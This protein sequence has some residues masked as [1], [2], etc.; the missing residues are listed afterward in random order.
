VAPPRPPPGRASRQSARG[1][2][3]WDE[4]HVVHRLAEHLALL[5]QHA[6]DAE[7]TVA[8]DDVLP[9]RIGPLKSCALTSEPIT[10]TGS[11]SSVSIGVRNR[12]CSTI[13][14]DVSMYSSVVPR[15][16][17]ISSRSPR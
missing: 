10:T 9:Q 6:H 16:C 15:T 14:D 3:R 4:D 2:A 1:T 11:L 7:A 13:S 12:P 17:T 8:D 5:L